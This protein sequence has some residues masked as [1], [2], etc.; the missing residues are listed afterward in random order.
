MTGPEERW[1]S[2]LASLSLGDQPGPTVLLDEGQPVPR[3]SGLRVLGCTVA[4]DV[5]EA[6]GTSWAAVV[7][8]ASGAVAPGG[9]LVLAAAGTPPGTEPV[10]A[11][12]RAA[13]VTRFESLLDSGFAVHQRA[14]GLAALRRARPSVLYLAPWI[15]FGGSDKGTLDWL[16]HLPHDRFRLYLHTTQPSDNPLLGDAESLADEAW[17]LPDLMTGA[18]MPQF[19]VNFVATRNVDVVHVMNSRLG[20]DLL[21]TLKSAYPH[22][23]T[24][25]QLHVEEEDRSGYCR[26]VTTRYDNLIDAYS[27]TSEDL[28]RKLLRYDVSPSKVHVIYTGVDVDSEFNPEQPGDG[29]LPVAPREGDGLQVLFPARLTA[30]KDPLLMVEVAAG[31][32]A[33]GSSSVIHAVGDGELRADVVRAMAAAGLE[34]RVVLHGASNVMA[35]WYRATDVTLLTSTFEGMP[36]V[37]YEAMAMGQPVVVPDLG[38]S[39]ELVDEATGFLVRDRA[40]AAEYVDALL[41]LERQPERRKAMGAAG[42]QRMLERFTVRQM[43]EGHAALYRRLSAEHAVDGFLG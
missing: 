26:F 22:L 35:P 34:D 21:P 38:G 2:A 28:R 41:T 19:V 5:G 4:R 8:A 23:R 32:R 7:R 42:R 12:E 1:S 29:P 27:V 37:I 17:C 20:Y 18:D 33:A 31:L 10:G 6:T 39:S 3:R 13:W 40:R 9:Y 36:F 25:V 43:A 11:E 16:R 24:V 15:T 30:Q 14:P